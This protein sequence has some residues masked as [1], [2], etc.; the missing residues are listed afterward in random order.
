[1]GKKISHKD[2]VQAVVEKYGNKFD[3]LSNY[4]TANDKVL[5]RCNKCGNE[6]TV[7]PASFLRQKIGC[8]KCY[9]NSKKT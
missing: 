9:S 6:R 2:F 7:T 3:V 4:K 1:M 5:V 8:K